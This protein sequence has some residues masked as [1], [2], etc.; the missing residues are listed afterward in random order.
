[1]K[2]EAITPDE[3]RD[4]G[5]EDFLGTDR[6]LIQRRLGT[7]A[8]GVVYEAWDRRHDALVALKV[9]RF[10]E[11]DALY[12]FKK[13]FR[14]LAD[15]RHPNLVTFYELV[16]EDG[17]WFLTQ[18]LVDG[19][20]F[21]GW[22]RQTAGPP[23]SPP[24]PARVR[25]SL[26]QLA[27]GLEFLHRSGRLHRD[28]KPPNVLVTRQGRVVLLDFGLIAELGA[29][30]QYESAVNPLAG[31][32][33]YM[34]PEQIEGLAAS[35]ASDW[36]GAGVMLYE[37]LLG[38]RP[39][40][41][42]MVEMM[43]AK[44]RGRVRPVRRLAPAV[45]ADLAAIC[46]GLLAPRPEDRLDGRA[47]LR[48][49]AAAIAEAA[50]VS[51]HTTLPLAVRP[52]LPFVGRGEALAALRQALEA[53]RHQAVMMLL[54]G[55][56]GMGKTSLASR[57]LDALQTND[58]SAVILRCRCHRQETVPYKAVDGLIDA[59]SRYL[60]GLDPDVASEL[61]PSSI[62]DLVRLFP[63]LGRVP[64]VA[65]AVGRGRADAPVSPQARRRRAFDALRQLL[66]RLA[67]RRH[68]VLFIDDV[69]WGDAD[70]AALLETL[71]RPPL[72][73]RL[74]VLAT[75]RSEL[76]AASP[77]LGAWN[78]R[79]ATLASRRTD[80]REL[81]LGALEAEEAHALA[82]ALLGP[83]APAA[84]VASVVREAA[85]H[86][87]FLVELAR[88]VQG[89]S[90]AGEVRL[91]DV[92]AT[93]I[94]ALPPAART[95]LELV[96]VAG[97]PIELEV[98][99]QAAELSSGI[100]EALVALRGSRLLRQRRQRGGV[101]ELETYHD[102]VR[103]IVLEGLDDE[104]L[105]RYHRNLALALESTGRAAPE[106]LAAHFRMTED[107]DHACGYASAAA[108][109][110]ERALAFDRAAQLYGLALEL[111]PAGSAR[112]REL[113]VK[114][115]GALANAGH[116]REAADA[117]LQAVPD[118]G[119][120][121]PLELQRRAAEK[122]LISGHIDRGMAV[123]RHVLRQ[124]GMT[125]HARPWRT[126]LDLRWRRLRL[127]L[128]GFRFAERPAAELDRGLLRR[129]DI[130][131]SVEI[132]LCLVDVLHASAFHARHLLLAL[133]AGEPQRI[134]RGLAMEVFFG[135]LDGAGAGRALA[136]AEELARRGEGSY[137]FGLAEL[138]AGMLACSRGAW[139]EAESHLAAAAEDL[140]E[141]PGAVW[142]LD[143]VEHFRVLSL[144]Y[145]G[146]WRSLLAEA[147]ELSE[148]ARARG[149]RYLDVH[150]ALWAGSLKELAADDPRAA[151]AVADE[152]I[153]RWSH[154]G[155]HYQH[156]GH[157]MAVAQAALYAGDGER[158]WAL[159]D[160]RWPELTRSL[161]QRMPMVYV[162]SLD[163]RA[164]CALAAAR[165][166]R[167]LRPAPGMRRRW[168]ARAD[169][170]ARRLARTGD[171]WALGLAA[172]IHAG[173]AWQRGAPQRAIEHLRAAEEQFR[174]SGMA[175][176]AAVARYRRGELTGGDE[177]RRST[178][179][180]AA[181]MAREGV[182]RPDRLAA[183]L[184]P[185]YGPRRPRPAP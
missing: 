21:V 57:F 76:A 114:L 144:L 149:D 55:A 156:F 6:F 54:H 98:A 83:G 35:P 22:L 162:Q 100:E 48:R 85:G 179:A 160:L 178:A 42:S 132:G 95:L 139:E 79:R 4:G 92:I 116:S 122:L 8:Y 128:G 19:V 41:D 94:A 69:H 30:G 113:L 24:D 118:P 153:G 9:L 109:L 16:E 74:L 119:E 3:R 177:G 67:G 103:E 107:R 82:Q 86:P 45:P 123:L 75:Y 36:Y 87:L 52:A 155:F 77:F 152:A 161:V 5:A 138:A 135:A 81:E 111:A 89:E 140:N 148:Q 53:S 104:A 59:L 136:R 146:R 169:A 166:R 110:A 38:E 130:C 183:M 117:Y 49:L 88:F 157:L 142:E 106:T 174:A 29:G 120:I 40:P 7:G 11:A 129:I 173:V 2:L 182:R 159:V 167:G 68:L 124:V 46:E 56:S 154:Q 61:L 65:A 105:R 145:R 1:M 99:R 133:R 31:T 90:P 127:R 121:D 37:A 62:A 51:A 60:G 80:L 71:V 143:T 32:P 72:A 101:E 108:A 27:R 150:L 112:R 184:A 50:P 73:P 134:A 164:R 12:R 91:S 20:D 34:A 125:M 93:R 168:L 126:L 58:R 151:V 171:G 163:L 26:A 147:A 175:L 96:A 115:A 158:A 15:A 137:A 10:V 33:A 185:G 13:A 43:A 63:V 39:F 181:A 97:K 180:A 14:S 23:P 70:S 47:V 84:G 66:G 28:V 18:E 102:R 44:R 165:P 64:A 131:W 170:D 17:C 78:A 172:M 141:E 25:D 176:N